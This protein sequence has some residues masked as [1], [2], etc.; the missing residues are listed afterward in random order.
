VLDDIGIADAP[1]GGVKSPPIVTKA[2][3]LA[4]WAIGPQA[5]WLFAVPLSATYTMRMQSN[6]YVE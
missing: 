3:L 2:D 6:F 1:I 5:N 4:L